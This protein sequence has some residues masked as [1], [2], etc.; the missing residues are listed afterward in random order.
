MKIEELIKSELEYFQPMRDREH[1]CSDRDRKIWQSETIRQRQERISLEVFDM[2]R[3]T[4]RYGPF[5]GLKLNRSPWWGRFDL[6]SQCL[7]LYEL[8]VL[9]KIE[10]ECKKG[11]ATLIDIG[12]ADGYYAVG[13]LRS[14]M[15]DH[16][17][18]FEQ[19]TDGVNAI[20][21]NWLSNGSPG[22]L[23]ILAQANDD[24]INSLPHKYLENSL[25]LIDIEGAEFDILSGNVF[26]KFNKCDLIVEI[27]NWVDD[28]CEKYSSLLRAASDTHQIDVIERLERPTVYI[29][30]L[31]D[32]TDDNRLLLVSERR[33]CMMRFLYLRP[34]EVGNPPV[35][36]PGAFK[37]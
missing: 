16:A 8:E 36:E 1:R 11:Y 21:T 22:S 32:F 25:I 10:R 6:G 35:S 2:C 19:S 20:R 34:K 33:P 31:R 5:K 15:V 24:S 37:G 18:C 23:E 14:G 3:G 29:P 26:K 28:F 7:G 17:I 13:M 4:V 12:A 9:K 30:E 27:H